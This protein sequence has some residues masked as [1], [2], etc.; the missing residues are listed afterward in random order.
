MQKFFEIE[1]NA[2]K[3]KGK[4]VG[5]WEIFKREKIALRKQSIFFEKIINNINIF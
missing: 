4:K 3:G 1:R 2:K 5:T